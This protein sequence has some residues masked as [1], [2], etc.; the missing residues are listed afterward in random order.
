M[1]LN[2]P[3]ECIEAACQEDWLETHET[4][5]ITIVGLLGGG[6][7]VLLS[8][9]LKSMYILIPTSAPTPQIAPAIISSI[10]SSGGFIVLLFQ[11]SLKNYIISS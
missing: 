9:F 1:T 4:F 10:E 7:G 3:L 5:V 6:I 8:Y 2:C 11:T